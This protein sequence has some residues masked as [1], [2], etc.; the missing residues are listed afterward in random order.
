[1]KSA[2]K[3]M[4]SGNPVSLILSFAFPLLLGIL[5]QQAYNIIDAV[6]VG[7]FLGAK[8]LAG[9]GASTSV[10]FLVLGFCTGS[11]TGFAVLVAQSFGA[12]DY[13]S[14]KNYFFISSILTLLI[15]VTVTFACA[16]CSHRILQM[17][18]TPAD[19]Y[20]DAYIYILIIFLGI[21][22]T[23]LYNLL[24]AVLRAIG[25]SRTPFVFLA[26]STFLNIALDLVF[27]ILFGW[28]CAGAA[29]ATI[30]SQAVS[31][32]LC[33]IYIIRKCALLH[34]DKKD[35]F[36]HGDKCRRL[37]IVGLPL[38]LQFSI[39][40]IGSMIMQSANN[41]LGSI[42]VSAFTAAQKIK[43]FAISPFD[44]LSTAVA[45]FVSQN[46]GARK[47]ERIK[48]G[49]RDGLFIGLVAGCLTGAVLVI[50]GR[51]LSMMFISSEHEDILDA[52]G[53]YLFIGGFFYPVI[54]FLNLSRLTVQGLGFSNRAIFSGVIEMIARIVV[55]VFFVPVMG[56]TAICFCDQA[57]WVS[58]SFFIFPMALFLMRKITREINGINAI[59]KNL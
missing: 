37:L 42:Y 10:Q 38:G 3:D 28:G 46:Y 33:L 48:R 54:P 49:F 4:T 5:F 34:L 50:F 6:I 45:T 9:V 35:C 41:S 51:T 57:A 8:A 47:A 17:L 25:N 24:A 12:K 43:V 40:A 15:A 56:Y 11:C 21:P 36:W 26:V 23:L 30:A 1:M 2:A 39:T 52:A 44:S 31:G 18:S 19:I 32:F 14:L 55:S 58:A 53:K 20:D 29:L 16:V 59:I 13:S 27:I 22:F 7:R